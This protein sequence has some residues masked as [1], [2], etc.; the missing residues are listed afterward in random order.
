[1]K[2]LIK[3]ALV[4]A[5][6][7]GIAQAQPY[8]GAPNYAPTAFPQAGMPQQQGFG[9]PMQVQQMPPGYA[10]GPYQTQT[11]PGFPQAQQRQV[12]V[13]EHTDEV[14]DANGIR[15]GVGREE[16]TAMTQDYVNAQSALRDH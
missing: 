3:I 6:L 1:M 11:A 8:G 7:G 2:R 13:A 10:Q 16:R 15:C 9:Q 5:L 4:P 14:Y 12:V